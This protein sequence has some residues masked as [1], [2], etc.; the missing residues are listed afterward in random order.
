MTVLDSIALD[1]LLS[2]GL[3]ILAYKSVFSTNPCLTLEVF[4]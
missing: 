4:K 3:R 2:S 1:A